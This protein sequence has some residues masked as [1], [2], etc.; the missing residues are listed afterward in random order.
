[1]IVCT[2][3]PREAPNRSSAEDPPVQAALYAHAGRAYPTSAIRRRTIEE[4]LW[5]PQRRL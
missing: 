2:D 1:M 5:V 4:A 3:S